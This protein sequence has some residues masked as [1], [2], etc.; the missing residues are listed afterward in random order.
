[1]LNMKLAAGY[2]NLA[3]HKDF[4]GETASPALS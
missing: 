1:M 2:A 4:N 3:Y